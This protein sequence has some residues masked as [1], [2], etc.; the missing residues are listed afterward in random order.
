MGVLIV[1][2]CN[3]AAF[4]HLNGLFF[5]FFS[6]LTA[7]N[8]MHIRPGWGHLLA[9]VQCN[10]KKKLPES[11]LLPSDPPLIIIIILNFNMVYSVLLIQ[12]HTHAS[13]QE[14][15]SVPIAVIPW[16]HSGHMVHCG[17]IFTLLAASLWAWN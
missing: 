9:T 8:Y 7:S 11:P 6:V 2:T 14:D 1:Y 3:W 15:A 4:Y 5:F 13:A 16:D 10:L 12:E 17:G